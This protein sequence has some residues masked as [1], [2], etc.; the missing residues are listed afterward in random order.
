MAAAAQVKQF[1]KGMSNPTY[2]I[3]DAS[4]D[5]WV[6]RKQ[7]PG[8]LLKGAHNVKRE[9]TVMSA[10][11]DTD[12]PVPKCLLFCDDPAILGTD[13]FVMEF[14]N[15]RVIEDTALQGEEY[16]PEFRAALY[17]SLLET[18]AALHSV[19]VIGVG[20]ETFGRPSGYVQRQLKTWGGQYEGG[21]EIVRDP[22]AWEA[23]GLTFHD[24]GTFMDGKTAMLSRIVELSISLIL[25]RIPVAD[26]L[27]HLNA[28]VDA[29]MGRM[30][31][32]PSGVVHGDYR[33]GNVIV[34]PTEP[35]VIAVLDWELC[36]I[37]N[38]LADLTY[39][40]MAW[41]APLIAQG[42]DGSGRPISDIGEGIPTE[43]QYKARYEELMG[44]EI[45]ES[46]WKFLQAFQMFRKGAIDHGVFSRSLQGNA[47]SSKAG[48][49][50]W[51]SDAAR[52]ALTMLGLR[53]SS[54]PKL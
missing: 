30:A 32:E 54:T 3:E 12:V 46:T 40:M 38:P 11:A 20:L 47:S 52:T 22:A 41:F 28:N 5:R 50:G 16:T 15:G 53:E 13:F 24:N 39:M 49:S 4:G 19:D 8:H 51:R 33:I 29:E 35:K 21:E 48:G 37:G 34:H 42:S 2:F 36:T 6:V 27:T 10:L 45:P 18:L 9:Y 7:P 1:N 17:D 43:E 44:W 25:R 14:V 23:K 31:P 26:L